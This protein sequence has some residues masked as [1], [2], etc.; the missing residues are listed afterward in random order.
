MSRFRQYL[1]VQMEFGCDSNV[2]IWVLGHKEANRD[3]AG[4]FEIK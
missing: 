1:D 3:I 4:A 2:Q